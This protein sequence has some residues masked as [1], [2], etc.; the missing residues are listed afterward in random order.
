VPRRVA[1]STPLDLAGVGEIIFEQA[2]EAIVVASADGVVT[3]WNA[4]A[5][6]MHGIA[7]SDAV[8]H[9]IDELIALRSI[10][11]VALSE[12]VWTTLRTGHGW[13]AR[14]VQR[15]LV[16]TRADQE[17]VVDAVV[18]PVPDAAGKFGGVFIGLDVAGSDRRQE[19]LL[20][21]QKMEAIGLL[22]AGVKHELNNPL[23]SILAFSQLI[24][25]DQSLPPELRDQADLLIQEARRTHRIVNGLLD[26]ARQGP[27]ERRPTSLRAVVDE[28]L[29]L[30]SYTFRPGQIE[31][32]V[33]IPDDIPSIPLD[34]AQIEQVLVNLTLNAAQAI[35][36]E[37]DHGTVRI[38][39][40]RAMTD[41]GRD[42]V[43]LSI[44][45]DGPGVPPELRSHLF[46]PFL[47][48]KAPGEGP[49]LGLSVSFGI[50]AGHGGT[51]RYEA[52][53]GGVGTT[54]IIELPV[55]PNADPTSGTAWVEPAVGESRDAAS[56]P[57]RVRDLE[58]VTS[59]RAAAPMRVLVLDDEASIR[60]FL[61]R[62]LRRNGYEPVAA[63]D[64]VSALEIIRLDPPR[65][66]LCDHR[67]AG[68]SGIAFH[69]AVAELDP[70]LA[71]RFAFMSGDVLNP[72]LHDFAIARGIVLLA[73]PFDIETVGRTVA[74]I[75]AP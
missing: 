12:A 25:T 68:M 53:P 43:R 35:E 4:A 60:D 16:G 23:A 57:A 34:R 39:A 5:E 37:S 22:V 52:G 69:E 24:R 66:I 7:A 51:L 48:S 64:G 63:V 17:T 50:V 30:Q 28:V 26:F 32:I 59:P 49:G 2:S 29:S 6:R 13:T 42:V 67:M 47:I 58:A 70:G 38:V 71:R 15:P 54:F 72:Q 18:S 44:T 75:A 62:I 9:P 19:E 73:K 31:A 14:V 41:D 45:D 1:E 21:A 3:A 33:E 55:S 56:T 36:T 11:G 8:G 20:Q 74:Q 10:E 61:A 40:E 46:V 27:S 65:A